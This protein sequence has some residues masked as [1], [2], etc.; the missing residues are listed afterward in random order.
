MRPFQTS[1]HSLTQVQLERFSKWL[2]S[3][4]CELF[5]NILRSRIAEHMIVVAENT[6]TNAEA[7]L[8]SGVPSLDATDNLKRISRYSI[9]IKVVEEMQNDVAERNRQSL[10]S[11]ELIKSI[12]IDML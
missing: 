10:P 5:L 11:V 8:A 4:E 3:P 12:E 1:P 7:F 6:A 9:A 2:G